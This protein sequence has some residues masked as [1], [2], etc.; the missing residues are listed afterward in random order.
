MKALY[1]QDLFPRIITG[2]SCG[3]IIAAII[4]SFK[5]SE[6]WKCFTE[7]HKVMT[8]K[9][10]RLSFRTFLEGLTKVWNGEDLVDIEYGKDG[11]RNFLGDM[12]FIEIY[13]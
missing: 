8:G 10:I 4:T 1:E 9:G 7:E 5:Y 12:T 11:L 2:S 3:S 13:N 6:L